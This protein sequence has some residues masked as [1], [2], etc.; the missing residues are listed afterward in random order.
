MAVW[1]SV[2]GALTALICAVLLLRAFFAGRQRLLLWSGLC[3]LGFTLANGLLVVDLLDAQL[4][5]HLMRL[6][7]A[8]IATLLLVYGLVWE[9]DQR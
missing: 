3:F 9:V 6:G 5:L 8:A 7:V 1:V 2:L 4:D